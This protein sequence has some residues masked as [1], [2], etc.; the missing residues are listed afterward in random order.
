MTKKLLNLL[1]YISYLQELRPCLDPM[2]TLALEAPNRSKCY[3]KFSQP[4][5]T[6]KPHK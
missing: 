3:L 4:H 2:V 1:S 5:K 6:F